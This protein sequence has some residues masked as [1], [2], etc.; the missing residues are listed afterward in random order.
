M[1][2]NAATDTIPEA[3]PLISLYIEPLVPTQEDP[4]KT[5]LKEVLGEYYL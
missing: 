3:F 5:K 1:E 4:H 2:T